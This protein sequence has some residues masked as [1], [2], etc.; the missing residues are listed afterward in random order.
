MLRAREGAEAEGAEGAARAEDGLGPAPRQS[1]MHR[2]TDTGPALP[3][4]ENST[5]LS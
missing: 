4:N 5:T 3:R 2:E 1:A